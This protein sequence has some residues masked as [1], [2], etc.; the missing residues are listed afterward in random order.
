MQYILFFMPFV[1]GLAIFLNGLTK[2]WNK[3]E[4]WW[5]NVLVGGVIIIASLLTNFFFR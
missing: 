2:L 3:E 5:T 1:F 4:G